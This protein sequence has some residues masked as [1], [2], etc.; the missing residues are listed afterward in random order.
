MQTRGNGE[1]GEDITHNASSIIDLPLSIPVEEAIVCGEAIV[2]LDDMQVINNMLP[3]DKKYS[4]ARNLAA[5]A[6][7][8]L[9][10]SICAARKIRF[11]AWKII[12]PEPSFF[13][14]ELNI[15]RKWGFVVVPHKYI[16]CSDNLDILEDSYDPIRQECNRK[17]YP[18]DGEVLRYEDTTYANSLGRTTHHFKSAIA[19][20]FYDEEERTRLR[21]IEWS[22][23]RT[24][25]LTP[26]AIFD[27]VELDGTSVNRASLHNVSIFKSL[28][29]G[30]SDEITVYKAN[31]IIPQIRENLT[32]SGTCQIPERCPIC[33]E[34]LTIIKNNNSEVLK[35]MNLSCDGKAI[36]ALENFVGREAMNIVG[37]SSATLNTLFDLEFVTKPLDLYHL[38][39]FQSKITTLEGFGEKSTDNLLEA[40]ERSRDCTMAQFLVAVGIPGVG[41]AQAKIIAEYFENKWD[42]FISAGYSNL[43]DIDGVGKI[44][45]SNILNW[46]MEKY[47]QDGYADIIPLLRFKIPESPISN[48]ISGKKFCVTGALEL[49]RNRSDLLAVIEAHGGKV[50]SCVGKNT[51]YLIM[52]GDSNSAKAKKAQAIGL[53]IL[54]EKE[55][56]DMLK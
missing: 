36:R 12:I 44:L 43:I 11:V 41:K 8:Q 42:K 45:A 39:S 37:L 21:E 51:D 17:K 1:E 46:I 48:R 29:L 34:P 47:T 2:C 15:L 56:V 35:C 33:G 26:V 5:G 52:N 54:K 27:P 30:F 38:R 3:Q 31:M 20:K 10:S 55:F 25:V 40:I 18:I 32:Q 9:D 49:F 6:V 13:S 53:T 22:M 24:G 14:Q 7:R 16:I 19:F 23:G 4:T 28:H 50:V